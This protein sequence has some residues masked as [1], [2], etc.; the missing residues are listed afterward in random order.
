MAILPSSKVEAMA[1]AK[2]SIRQEEA[3]FDLSES[4]EPTDT[5]QRIQ[6]WVQTQ[7]QQRDPIAPL[8][9][10]PHRG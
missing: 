8:V 1:K 5:R 3:W 2:E 7:G 10:H 9:M 6:T 4:S